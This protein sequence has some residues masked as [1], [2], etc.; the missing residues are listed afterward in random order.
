LEGA[1]KSTIL[2]RLLEGTVPKTMP[3]VGFN[4]ETIQRG[5]LSCVLTDLGGGEK[6]RLL[7]KH[8]IYNQQGLIWVVDASRPDDD[9]AAET[10]W[11][12]SRALL[13]T[14]REYDELRRVPLL[15]LANK[16][17]AAAGTL[18]MRE[19]TEKLGLRDIDSDREREWFIQACSAFNG[20]GMDEGFEWLHE[21]YK[22]EGL[23]PEASA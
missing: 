1:G 14:M 19:I 7:W 5:K 9:T 13:K 21:T 22:K 17:D 23:V 8:Y 16:Q 15:V 10:R 20:E 3:T 18:D 6:S 11:E 12:E 2:Y 4:N